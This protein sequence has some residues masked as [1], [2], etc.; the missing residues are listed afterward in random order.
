MVLLH[1]LIHVLMHC[2]RKIRNIP[3]KL[4]V[5][6]MRIVK[7]LW[8]YVFQLVLLLTRHIQACLSWSCGGLIQVVGQVHS[9]RSQKA[10]GFVQSSRVRR[11]LLHLGS[12]ELLTDM[13]LVIC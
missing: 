2:G 10:C 4:S 1:L 13:H 9:S 12:V 11:L 7:V 6:L 8:L 3:A 5:R